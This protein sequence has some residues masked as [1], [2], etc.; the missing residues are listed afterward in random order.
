MRTTW[1]FHSA[2]QLIFGSGAVATLGELAGQLG[3]KRLLLVTDV[4]LCRA[5][6]MEQVRK[7]LDA[8][9]IDVQVFDGGMPEP[10]FD[11]AE[12]SIAAGRS[13]QPD[14]VLGLGGGSNMD[15]AKITATVLT[16]DGAIRDYVGDCRIPGPVLPLICIP[17]CGRAWRLSIRG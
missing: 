6:L 15:L 1:T 14:G 10:S 5:G 4:P 13:F 8:A 3:L 17:T 16:H 11:V 7:P 9:S 2:G 12:Q